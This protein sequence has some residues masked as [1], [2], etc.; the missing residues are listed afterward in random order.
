M[1]WGRGSNGRPIDFQE[2]DPEF[3]TQYWKKK[4]EQSWADWKSMTF[5]IPTRV[6]KSQA[7]PSCQI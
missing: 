5:L 1:D 2:G 4:K 6:P 7:K 3:N